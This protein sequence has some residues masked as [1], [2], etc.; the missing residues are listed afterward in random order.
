MQFTNMMRPR[1][2]RVVAVVLVVMVCLTFVAGWD[3]VF[4]QHVLSDWL[5]RAVRCGTLYW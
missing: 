1:T 2:I 3:I 5:C 4:G